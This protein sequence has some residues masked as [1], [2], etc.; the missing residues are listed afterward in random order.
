MKKTHIFI[1][2]FVVAAIGVIM[3]LFA[4]TSTYTDFSAA[5]DNPGKE[6]HV[7]GKLVKDKPIVYDTKVDANKFTFYMTDQKNVERLVTYN[8]AK[9]QDFEKSE[10]VVVIGKI[11]NDAFLASSLLL[12][13][14]SK[15]N[16]KKPESFGDK[17]FK[18]VEKPAAK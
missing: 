16:D 10:Q 5:V 14:P 1:L 12:K 9:P 13:C 2:V 8:G 11:E 17:D 7:I 3:S 18:A 4:N 6:F 15:Y